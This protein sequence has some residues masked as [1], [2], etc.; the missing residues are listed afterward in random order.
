M[1]V[2]GHEIGFEHINGYIVMHLR[3]E[4]AL[5]GASINVTEEVMPAVDDYLD[6]QLGLVGKPE[7]A[8]PKE[9]KK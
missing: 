7:M 2:F 9:E 3:D 8:R 4:G 5:G 1:K 6:F